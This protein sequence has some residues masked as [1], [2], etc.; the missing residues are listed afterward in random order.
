MLRLTSLSITETMTQKIRHYRM[1]YDH[2]RKSL[3]KQVGCAAAALLLAVVPAGAQIAS[4]GSGQNEIFVG[5]ELEHYLRVLQLRGQS[6]LYPWSIRSFSP[7]EVDRIL[8]RDSAHPWVGRYGL[9]H[10]TMSPRSAV[11]IVSPRASAIY[12]S[13]FPFGY[14]DGPIWAGRGVT[15][16]LH[17][18]ISARFGP[19][20]LVIAPVIYYAQNSAFE[21]AETGYTGRLRFADPGVTELIDLPQRFGDAPIIQLDPGQSTLRLDLPGVAL[22]VSTANQQWGPASENPIVLGNNAP[23]FLHAFIGS[24][25]PV[26]VGLGRLHARLIWGTLD[27][28]NYSAVVGSESRRFMAGLVATFT[29]RGIPGLEVGGS[30]F[31][32]MPWQVGGPSAG[33]FLRPF[34]S[35]YRY[36]EPDAQNPDN[37][38]QV[39]SVFARWVLPRS[40]FEVYGEFGKEDRNA[41]FRDV[42]LEPEHNSAYVLGFQKAM[43]FS[44][45]RL[46]A[47]RG[48]VMN[49]QVSHVFRTRHQSAIYQHGSVRQGHTQRGQLLGSAWGYGGAAAVVA[50]DYYH[51]R[52]RWTFDWSRLIRAEKVADVPRLYWTTEDR[53]PDSVDLIHTTGV[54]AL[55]FVG[56]FDLVGGLRG[57][58]NSNRNFISNVFNVN[59]SISIRA[60]I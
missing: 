46:L 50:A 11:G 30:R 54:E 58:Y 6:E 59:A 29:P 48:E 9:E 24:S 55:L 3:F 44:A 1:R 8:P 31:F 26:N 36:R 14:N 42:L 49:A 37:E 27:Q 45:S 51:T 57:V 41:D 12:N 2:L 22:G 18:G 47:L 7:Q 25:A 23:G 4:A 13:A 19:A 53:D 34:E 10:D 40:G 32:H 33:D 20:S 5:S 56:R 15:T 60:G 17:G 43:A 16:A 38:N 52:G 28:S 21:L 35:F 39:A